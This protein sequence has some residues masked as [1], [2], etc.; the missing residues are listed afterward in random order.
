MEALRALGEHAKEHAGAIAARLEDEG[1]R[2]RYMAVQL[3]IRHEIQER[4][5]DFSLLCSCVTCFWAR[6][7]PRL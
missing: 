3:L 1:W 7:A 4:N 6:R 5:R 2:V